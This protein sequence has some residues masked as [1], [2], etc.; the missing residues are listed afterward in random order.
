MRHRKRTVGL[1]ET[2][3]LRDAMLAFIAWR[4]PDGLR[5]RG[6]DIRR[7]PTVDWKGRA[8]FTLRCNGP[9][10]NGPHDVN[11]PESLLWSLIDLDRFLCAYHR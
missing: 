10:G 6:E 7:L 5:R 3:V 11:V 1:H 8:L 9:F 4:G 2:R